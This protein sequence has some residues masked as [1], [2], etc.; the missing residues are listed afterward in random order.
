[1]L[2][3]REPSPSNV[4]LMTLEFQKTPWRTD[5]SV[6]VDLRYRFIKIKRAFQTGRNKVSH[7]SSETRSK[8]S[9]L[10]PFLKKNTYQK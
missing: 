6:S 10:R 1:M 5:S 4:Y 9:H 8:Q 3:S 7:L 2:K